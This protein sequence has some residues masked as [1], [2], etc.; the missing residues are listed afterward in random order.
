MNVKI[1]DRAEIIQSVY[2][3]TVGAIVRVIHYHGEHSKYG[4]TWLVEGEAESLETYL[5]DVSNLCHCPD[6][7]LRKIDDPTPP[8]ALTRETEL[9]NKG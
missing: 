4:P 8:K 7:W 5:G 2:G 9:I 1:G 3:R 6:A